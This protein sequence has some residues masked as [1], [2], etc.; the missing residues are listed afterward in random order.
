MSDLQVLDCADCGATTLRRSP[1]QLY[2]AACSGDRDTA[3]KAAWRASNPPAKPNPVARAR[4]RSDMVAAGAERSVASRATMFWP[5]DQ[6][7]LDFRQIVRVSIPFDWAASKNGVWRMGR[8]GHVYARK[9]G[10]AVRES[11]TER[12]RRAS[13]D[14]PWY[15][16][17]VWI[18]IFVEKPSHRG[19]ATNFIDLICDAVK[20]AIGV[21]DRWY[22]IR[23]LDWSIVKKDPR[24]IV[25]VGQ[26]VGE[27]HKV[28]SHCGRTLTLD[29]F[30]LNRSTKDGRTRVCRPCGAPIRGPR[31]RS[32][33]PVDASPVAVT[34][35]VQPLPEE[36]T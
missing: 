2:C 13:G 36:A 17:K 5:A 28:C 11:L 30:G 22:S 26:E 3:R 14:E 9:E 32:E 1:S 33:A 27:D 21:D 35:T 16:G 15:Q 20:D 24:L 8:G 25:G 12:I 7:E 19:D 34:A 29:C 10:V 18:D 6:H 4:Q 31:K 23:R